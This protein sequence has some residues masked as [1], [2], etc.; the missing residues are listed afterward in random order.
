M[1]KNF[2]HKGLERFFR[3]GDKSG[4]QAHH[5]N[6]LKLQLFMLNRATNPQD[7][8]AAGWK[9]HKLVG[10]LKNHYAVTVNGNWRLTFVFNGKDAE[11]VDYQDYH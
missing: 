8:N 7:M 4:I 5:A 2:K 11:I 9:L 10:N 3:T 1:I 6:K